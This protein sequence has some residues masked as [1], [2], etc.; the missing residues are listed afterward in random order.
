MSQYA[1]S[2]ENVI[3][4]HKTKVLYFSVSSYTQPSETL[5]LGVEKIL[6]C[7]CFVLLF[8]II[9]FCILFSRM[10]LAAEAI[11]GTTIDNLFL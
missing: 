9:G 4:G 6:F 3:P 5:Y 1:G 11:D 2:H 7:F 10:L 8:C